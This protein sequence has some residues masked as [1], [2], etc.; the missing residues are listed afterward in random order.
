MK[1]TVSA[2]M[3]A[4]DVSRPAAG[5]VAEPDVLPPAPSRSRP[6][7]AGPAA[8][9]RDDGP[10]PSGGP[11][12]ADGRTASGSPAGPRTAP[13]PGQAGRSADAAGHPPAG[14]GSAAGQADVAQAD[15]AQ[16]GRPGAR[17]GGPRKGRGGRGRGGI[18]GSWPGAGQADRTRTDRNHPGP[19]PVDQQPEASSPAAAG[20]ASA[21]SPDPG[22]STPVPPSSSS[23]SPV[24][25]SSSPR[26]PAPPSPSPHNPS[27]DSPKSVNPISY[28]PESHDRGSAD[29]PQLSQDPAAAD[30]DRSQNRAGQDGSRRR[31]EAQGARNRP[32]RRRSRRRRLASGH[33][34][35]GEQALADEQPRAGEQ[36]LPPADDQ[37]SGGSSPDAS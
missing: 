19:R 30:T 29:G 9:L 16:A 14:P 24:P 22:S 3:R 8:A 13:A 12:L 36:A 15:V 20:R 6:T 11:G 34:D 5:D 23:R 21:V 7:P 4:R 26:S 33:S 27:S 25:P 2:A 18:P 35:P 32:A 1:I 28:N 31:G 37:G 10:G 17:P